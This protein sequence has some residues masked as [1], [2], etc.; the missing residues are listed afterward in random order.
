MV[1]S[2]RLGHAAA[3]LD[4]M[5]ASLR[6]VLARLLAELAAFGGAGGAGVADVGAE[7][8]PFACVM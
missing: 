3:F 7:S 1:A 5:A 4:T 8:T 2:G 6:A